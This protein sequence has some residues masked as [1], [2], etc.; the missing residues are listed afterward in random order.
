MYTK[1]NV[2]IIIILFQTDEGIHR[3]F[4]VLLLFA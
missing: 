1:K 2:F 4:V 3:E